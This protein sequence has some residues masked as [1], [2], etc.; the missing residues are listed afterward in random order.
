MGYE[1]DVLVD[2]ITIPSDKV[3]D[4]LAAIN[5]LHEEHVV[6]NQGGGGMWSGGKKQMSCYS[7]VRNPASTGFDTLAEALRSWR[8]H[9]TEEVDGSVT[10]D[11]FTGEKLGDDE[12][13][14]EAIAPYVRGNGSIE[15]RGEDGAVWRYLFRAGAL[16]DYARAKYLVPRG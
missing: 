10:I 9:T 4:C 12:I 13:L 1:I 16:Y 2:N 8:W 7:W 3:Q 11:R 5:D 6:A 14:F 15:M